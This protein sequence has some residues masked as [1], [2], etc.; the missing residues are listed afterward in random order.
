MQEGKL[1]G[2]HTSEWTNSK[3]MILR[4][5]TILG[6]EKQWC[7]SS[8]QDSHSNLEM[9]ETIG[10]LDEDLDDQVVGATTEEY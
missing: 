2:S 6:L 10:M 9:E 1:H 4:L 5:L 7:F 3:E 8:S